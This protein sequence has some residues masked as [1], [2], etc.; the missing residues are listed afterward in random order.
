MHFQWTSCK[1][2][3]LLPSIV[4]YEIKS[5]VDSGV[6]VW[7][8]LFRDRH[9]K[10]MESKSNVVIVITSVYLCQQKSKVFMFIGVGFT[11]RGCS[12]WDRILH[13]LVCNNHCQLI[14]TSM[15]IPMPV[16]SGIFKLSPIQALSSTNLIARTWQGCRRNL[17]SAPGPFQIHVRGND[18]SS[19]ARKNWPLLCKSSQVRMLGQIEGGGISKRFK[20]CSA[21][22]RFGW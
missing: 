4:N 13:Y 6:L 12:T 15:S 17:K 16:A 2:K 8:K 10:P 22:P 5:E 3:E 7:T 18:G 14:S 1:I 11:T 21:A 20:R 9:C 19:Q